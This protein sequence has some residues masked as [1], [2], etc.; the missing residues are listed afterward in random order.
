MPIINI[1]PSKRIYNALTK[2]ISIDDAINDLIDN[3]IDNWKILRKTKLLGVNILI[4]DSKIEIKDNA[5]GIDL[6]TLPLLLMPGGTNRSGGEGIKGIWG[7]GAK[8]SLFFLGEK[9]KILTRKK[10]KDGLKLE[11]DED[12]FTKDEG[13][14]KWE[15]EYSIDNSIPEEITKIIIEKL[16]VILNP[17]LIRQIRESIIS[18]YQDE[19]VKKTLKIIFNNEIVKIVLK[20]PWS[21]SK[22]APPS[23]YITDIPVPHSDRKVHTEITLGVM[24]KPGEEYSYGIDFIGNGRVILHNNHDWRMGFKKGKLGLAHPT[25]NRFKAVVRVTGDSRDIPWNSAKN[26]INTNHPIYVNMVDLVSQVSRQYVSFLRKNYE[27]TSILFRDEAD[28]RD[29]IKI[30]FNYGSDFRK[31]VNE[32]PEPKNEINISFKILKED[33]NELVEYFGLHCKPRK[34][35]GLFVFNKALKEVRGNDED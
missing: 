3:A 11:V 13:E 5:G 4:S 35:V 6:K 10:N 27:V 7:I 1:M 12:W 22:Y 30:R 17:F 25:I 31:V 18:V 28:E 23:R 24:T 19:I 14:N 16:K 2:D 33:Y 15:I 32:Y 9:I 29:I 26:D 20:I 21:K 8:R 34:A